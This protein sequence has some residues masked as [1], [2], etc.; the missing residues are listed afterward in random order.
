MGEALDVRPILAV[1][2]AWADADLDRLRATRDEL[3]AQ[4]LHHLP[5]VIPRL[6]QHGGSRQRAMRR[7]SEPGPDALAMSPMQNLRRRSEPR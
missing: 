1:L 2:N 6:P 3:Q 5:P 4:V 7:R